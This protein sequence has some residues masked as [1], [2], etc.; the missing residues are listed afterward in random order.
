MVTLNEAKDIKEKVRNFFKKGYKSS[1]KFYEEGACKYLQ[2]AMKRNADAKKAGESQKNRERQTDNYN[3]AEILIKMPPAHRAG[4]CWE[5]SVLSAY[6]ILNDKHIDRD[7]ICIASVFYPAD[8]MFCVI[9]EVRIKERQ[10]Y[11]SISDF[12]SDGSGLSSIIVD[13][14]LNVA[15]LAR[16]YLEEVEK[17]LDKWTMEGKRIS[18][19]EGPQ[20]PGWYAPNGGYKEALTIRGPVVLAPF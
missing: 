8:H 18:W 5:M 6:Y 13:P 15:C 7:F 12:I 1:N 10:V 3:L 14:W 20:G 2:K 17:K 16:N 19:A 9:S 11:A 4:N